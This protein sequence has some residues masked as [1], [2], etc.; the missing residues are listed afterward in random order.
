MPPICFEQP[1]SRYLL[2]GCLNVEEGQLRLLAYSLDINDSVVGNSEESFLLVAYLRL[3]ALFYKTKP[4]N[5]L[6]GKY[7]HSG[8]CLDPVCNI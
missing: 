1:I 4:S 7:C 5:S 6:T 8:L 2:L 3:V